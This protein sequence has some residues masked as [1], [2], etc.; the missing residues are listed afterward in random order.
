MPADSFH[1]E[2]PAIL[3][4]QLSLVRDARIQ[5]LRVW[6]AGEFES[7][8]FYELCDRFGLLVMQ[9]FPIN[10]DGRGKNTR[11]WEKAAA[12]NIFR[13]RNHPSLVLW[14][15]GNE[16]CAETGDSAPLIV[17]AANLI[18]NLD[19]SRE[20]ME[21]SPVNGDWHIYPSFTDAARLWDTVLADGPFI[22]ECGAR[23]MPSPETWEKLLSEESFRAVP[24]DTVYAPEKM[25]RLYPEIS[26][27]CMEYPEEMFRRGEKFNRI[28]EIPL[29]ELS[30]AVNLAAAEFNRIAIEVCRCAWPQNG[31]LLLWAWKRPWPSVACQLVDGL[32][33]PV[34][35]YYAAKR[36]YA[37]LLPCLKLRSLEC[38]PGE[39]LTLRPFLLN[40][41]GK[42]TQ[43]CRVRLRL[44]SPR[45]QECFSAEMKPERPRTDGVHAYDL[46]EQHFHIP[47]TFRGSCFFAVL[48]AQKPEGTPARNFYIFRCMDNG[49]ARTLRDQLAE[50]PAHL[51]LQI[52]KQ[53]ERRIT[54]R[55]KNSGKL[56]SAITSVSVP[57][58]TPFAADDSA[59]WLDPDESKDITLRFPGK[60]LPAALA[61]SSWNSPK[62]T[63]NIS[64]MEKFS[65]FS[66]T[67]G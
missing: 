30:G 66:S 43:N 24:G 23:C 38:T 5:M 60:K 29:A 7:D 54:L 57:D 16:F 59:F 55:I 34:Q 63:A 8:C 21:S 25:A 45:L 50:T 12:W 48:D 61:V 52:L 53:E 42:E 37:P 35:T 65:F 20:F 41:N 36:G 22:S 31:G 67:G 58:G 27:F 1:D 3:E 44:F 46:P 28:R 6:G 17:I 40:E 9:D 13:L 64:T 18:R 10:V 49:N 19:G 11:L 26:H 62:I 51:E 47:E 33:Q 56:P 2:N 32:G 14:C 15:G 4:W 39:N